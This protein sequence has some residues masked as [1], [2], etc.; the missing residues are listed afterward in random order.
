[1][2][3]AAKGAWI[4]FNENATHL[5]FTGTPTNTQFGNYVLSIEVSDPFQMVADNV[6]I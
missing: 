6:D 1:M 4:T 3:D 5:I 2:S